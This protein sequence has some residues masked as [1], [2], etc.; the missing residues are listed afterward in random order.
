MK[1]KYIEGCIQSVAVCGSEMCTVG[2]MKRGLLMVW[3]M[4]LERNVE[5]ILDRESNEWYSF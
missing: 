1:K 5:N 4:E 3:N 2:K